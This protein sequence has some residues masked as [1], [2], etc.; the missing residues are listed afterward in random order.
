MSPH[1]VVAPKWPHG[2]GLFRGAHTAVTAALE[3]GATNARR[4]GSRRIPLRRNNKGIPVFASWD[5]G[6]SDARHLARLV[7]PSF[8]SLLIT[9]LAS[10]ATFA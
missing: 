9:M 1:R 7:G 10:V 2:L 4:I 5:I 6:R 8:K 3:Y